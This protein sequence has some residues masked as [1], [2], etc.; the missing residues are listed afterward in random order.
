MQILQEVQKAAI[1]TAIPRLKVGQTVKVH[2]KIK[3]GNKERIQIF[4][5]LIIKM[6]SGHGADKT[7]T[8]RKTVG[9]IG[10]EKCYPLY[11]PLITLEVVK[12]AKVRRAKLYYMRDRS[13]KSARLKE[14]FVSGVE[15]EEAP[16]MPMA[17]E[18]QAAEAMEEQAEETMEETMPEATEAQEEVME[19]APVEE[20]TAE[21]PKEEEKSE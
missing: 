17:Q 14:R 15:M 8:V 6:N 1:K 3:E 7:I 12:E 21:E 2:Q 9:G 5:G 18:E 11:S 13:G 20:A 4:E 19:E 16:E 10:V